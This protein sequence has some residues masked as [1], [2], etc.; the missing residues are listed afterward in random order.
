M[1]FSKINRREALKLSGVGLLG[2][3]LPGLQDDSFGAAPD[4]DVPV[5]TLTN[6][7]ATGYWFYEPAGLFIQKGQKVR[8]LAKQMGASIFAFHPSHDNHELRIPENAKPFNSGV[9]PL[10]RVEY[11]GRNIFE[12]TFD[13]EGTYDYYSRDQENVGMVGRIVVGKPGGPGEKPPGYGGK[14]GRAVVWPDA[15][16]VF[17]RLPSAE[18]VAKKSLPFPKD[19]EGKARPY[20]TTG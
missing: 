7:Y 9:A 5:I 15:I 8:W 1:S 19:L 16:E 13:V 6:S 12:W 3:A 4:P 20:S 2:L 18:I 17:K 11:E 14:E 10:M